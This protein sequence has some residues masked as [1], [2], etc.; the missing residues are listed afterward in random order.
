M[1]LLRDIG[2]KRKS[3][4]LALNCSLIIYECVLSLVSN[5]EFQSG[6]EG[7]LEWLLPQPWKMALEALMRSSRNALLIPLAICDEI[8]QELLVTTFR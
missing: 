1:G 6:F 5:P 2:G 3:S 8:R 4:A 7:L